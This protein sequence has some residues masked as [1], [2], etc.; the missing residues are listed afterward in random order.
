MDERTGAVDDH[1]SVS[2][3]R[4]DIERTQREM[5]RTID[6][7]QHRL[8]P[9][10]MMEQTKKSVREAGVR[11]SRSVLDRITSNPI[12]AAMVGVG[13]WLLIRENGRDDSSEYGYQQDFGQ[14]Y[15]SAW[16][17]N[18]GNYS[19]QGFSSVA[20]YRD[21]DPGRFAETRDRVGSMAG[22]ARERVGGAVDS[23]RD[24]V[25]GAVDSARSAASN[26][27]HSVHD[28]AERFGS[29]SRYRMQRAGVETRDFLRDN[30]M[31]A[32]FAALA[33]GALVGAL[34]PETER[35]HELM[36]PTR[37][38]LYGQARDMAHEGLDK[39]K[40]VATHVASA[41]TTAAKDAAKQE[42]KNVKSDKQTDVNQNLGVGGTTA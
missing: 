3:I 34:I 30:P 6:E 33:L 15:G 1:E 23:A 28:S 24:K 37:D 21:I 7:I 12:P 27:I 39:A 18:A 5:G 40:D 22:E 16:D 14:Q 29:E 9:H 36:G 35:E 20:E 26:A 42:V 31:V 4:R 11:T 41:A 17:R 13:L 25:S 19:G 32:G 2:E 38:R 10:Y 8:S